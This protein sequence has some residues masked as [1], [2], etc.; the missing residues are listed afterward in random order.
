M[1]DTMT[2]PTDGAIL[3]TLTG[4]YRRFIDRF[5]AGADGHPHA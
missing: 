2:D 5:F 3:A 1:T 4:I